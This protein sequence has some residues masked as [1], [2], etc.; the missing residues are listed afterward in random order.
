MVC[1]GQ[2]TKENVKVKKRIQNSCNDQIP[3]FFNKYDKEAGMTGTA[4]TEER[5]NLEEIYGM[6]VVVIQQTNQF[7][8]NRCDDANLQRQNV[9]MN[10]VVE[11]IVNLMQKDSLF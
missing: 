2:S 4:L 11:D 10:A 5:R 7:R 6:D 9:K 3:N 1:I 8:E